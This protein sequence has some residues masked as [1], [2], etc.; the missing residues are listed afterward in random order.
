VKKPTNPKSL[1]P[2][3]CALLSV[4]ACAANAG[5]ITTT[6]L[7]ADN[8]TAVINNAIF[9]TD[10]RGKYDPFKGTDCGGKGE[11][12]ASDGTG[13]FDPFL[14]IQ[15]STD[16]N[17]V[18]NGYN[19]NGQTQFETTAGSW[20]HSLLLSSIP[21]KNINGTLY[22]EFFL[23]INESSNSTG[24]YLSLDEFRLFLGSVGD[25]NSY[26]LTTNILSYASGTKAATK[27][28]D[29]DTASTNNTIGLTGR[30]D[31]IDLSV[32][33][34]N[35]VFTGANS[36][37]YVYLYS[38]FGGKGTVSSNNRPGALPA[39]NYGASGDYEE[40]STLFCIPEPSTYWLL[41]IGMVGLLRFGR[42]SFH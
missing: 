14:R 12:S 10:L 34:R 18:E 30:S 11:C 40:W 36:Q 1:N 31:A 9:T 5:A 2:L 7:T 42:W 13:A 32:L 39:G 4:A 35:S 38:S 26:S 22:R 16:T 24:K 28:Y 3:L 15:D 8:K 17:T 23:D 29:L 37:S 41:G 19:T 20:T 33:V 6:N 25:L 21:T 27:V